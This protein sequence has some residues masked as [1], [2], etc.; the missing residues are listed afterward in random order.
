MRVCVGLLNPITLFSSGK[1]FSRQ[2]LTYTWHRWQASYNC[3]LWL[4]FYAIYA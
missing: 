3:Y 4:P 1:T 2:S